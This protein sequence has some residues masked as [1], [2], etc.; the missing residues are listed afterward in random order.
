MRIEF[1]SKSEMEIWIDALE[2]QLLNMMVRAEYVCAHRFGAGD[3]E[4]TRVI[5]VNDLKL[6]L[7]AS[8]AL[9]KQHLTAGKD[10]QI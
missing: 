9:M 6:E 8:K 3:P 1:M 7:S 10:R 2:M 5:A 4:G